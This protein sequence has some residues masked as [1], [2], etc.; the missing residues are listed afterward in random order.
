MASRLIITKLQAGVYLVYSMHSYKNLNSNYYKVLT[1]LIT[2]Q[3]PPSLDNRLAH[4]SRHM[5]VE[6]WRHKPWFD[7]ECS[8]AAMESRELREG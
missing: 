6:G 2:I 8:E 4:N 3:P 1:A 5:E 7:D